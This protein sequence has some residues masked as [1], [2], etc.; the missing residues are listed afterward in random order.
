MSP[1]QPSHPDPRAATAAWHRHES[2]IGV[3]EHDNEVGLLPRME[4]HLSDPALHRAFMVLLV[5][6]AG[7]LLLTRRSEQKLLWPG[8]WADSCAGHPRAGESVIEA[9]ER[10]VHEEL[11]CTSDLR[12]LGSFVYRAEYGDV[13]CEYELCHVLTGPILGE[14]SPDAAEV[15]EFKSFG[16]G[17][18]KV[19]VRQ[20]PD[21]FVPWLTECLSV[22]PF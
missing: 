6:G 15:A 20:R 16:P 17:V 22:F 7:L 18:L 4:A 8:F 5:D 2:V 13:G 12:S 1:R 14:V 21:L 19:L 9:G 3:D 10:R 11:G